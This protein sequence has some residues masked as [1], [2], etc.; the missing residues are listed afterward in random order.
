MTQKKAKIE[1]V[2]VEEAEKLRRIFEARP[3]PRLS[4]AKFGDQYE[5]GSQGVVWQYLNARIPLNVE[6]AVRFARGLNCSVADFSPRL[7]AELAALRQGFIALDEIHP[8]S[9][10]ES[11]SRRDATIGSRRF[12]SQAPDLPYEEETYLSRT[13]PAGSRNPE[14]SRALFDLARELERG[15]LSDEARQLLTSEL[16]AKTRFVRE[17]LERMTKK[18]T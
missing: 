11:E 4:Q 16:Q 2:H 8:S 10:S 9:G 15:D 3:S 18:D 13:L 17:A 14:V 1:P 12:D 7:A 5:I 6:Q